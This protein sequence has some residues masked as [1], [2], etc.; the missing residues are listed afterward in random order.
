MESEDPDKSAE[1]VKP[2]C[3]RTVVFGLREILFDL[4]KL[5]VRKNH[6]LF[7]AKVL[8]MLLTEDS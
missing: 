7:Y 3:V 6:S 2:L 5:G 1:I 4:C 8:G